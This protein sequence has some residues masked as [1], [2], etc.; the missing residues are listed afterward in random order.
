MYKTGQ[1]IEYSNGQI[2]RVVA[3]PEGGDVGGAYFVIQTAEGFAL[4][5]RDLT[6]EMDEEVWCLVHE[7]DPF[8]ATLAEAEA[9]HRAE[10][11]RLA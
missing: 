4:C 5:W 7:A 9:E 8:R 11:V 6:A 2:A 10:L 1:E 3:L